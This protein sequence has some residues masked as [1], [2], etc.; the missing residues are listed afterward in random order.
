MQSSLTNL[1]KKFI[2]VEEAVMWI[3]K[4]RQMIGSGG[5]KT[6]IANLYDTEAPD[7]EKQHATSSIPAQRM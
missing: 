7:E 5:G 2:D 4:E 1:I 6:T 3:Q